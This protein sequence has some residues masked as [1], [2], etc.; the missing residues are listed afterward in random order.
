MFEL[1]VNRVLENGTEERTYKIRFTHNAFCDNNV[2]D[3]AKQ[4]IKLYNEFSKQAEEEENKNITE[5][6]QM[7]KFLCLLGS[8]VDIGVTTRDL[9]FVGCKKYNALLNVQEAGDIIDDY[10]D[11]E[12]H[13][14]IELFMELVNELMNSGFFKG[15]FLTTQETVQEQ[16]QL[17]EVK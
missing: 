12:N 11:E 2:M 8:T 10:L 14:L 5:S 9:I 13:S 7:E 15:M 4:A 17:Q 1:K 3:S 6:E 16:P